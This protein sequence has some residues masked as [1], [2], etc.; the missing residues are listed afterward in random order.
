VEEDGRPAYAAW[1]TFMA[2]GTEAELGRRGV[3]IIAMTKDGRSV[4][5]YLLRYPKEGEAGERGARL[6]G[7]PPRW[8]EGHEPRD[9]AEAGA[10]RAIDRMRRMLARIEDLETALD[11]PLAVWPRLDEAWRRAENAEEPRLA[12]IVRQARPRAMPLRLRLVEQRLRRVLR[13]ERALRPI[14]RVEEMDRA[15]MIWL[16]RQPG[17]SLV[18][19]AGTDQRVMA[20]VRRESFDTLENRVVHAYARLAE[21]TARGW[22]RAHPKARLSERYRRVEAFRRICRRTATDLSGMGVGIADA[23][24]TPNYVLSQDPDYRATF[25]AWRRLLKDERETDDLWGWHAQ[26]WIDFCSL[27][28]VLCLMRLRDAELVAQSPIIWFG[29]PD[30]GRWFRQANPLAVVWLRAAGL[31]VEVQSRPESVAAEQFHAGAPLWL[32]IGW[33]SG[34]QPDRVAI[35]PLHG[36]AP[37]DLAAAARD[38]AEH[39]DTIGR[40]LPGAKPISAGL[41]LAQSFEGARSEAAERGGARVSALSLGAEGPELAEG[42]WLLESWIAGL[43]ADASP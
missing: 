30:R 21:R 34:G 37:P 20:I 17:A 29:A 24:A 25:E 40:Q 19:R 11:D 12:D 33:T 6:A 9:A 16:S 1:D 43:G 14:D 5:R 10:A 8:R 42:M 38:A 41:I 39:L 15:G 23:G 4:G 22:M 31:V 7:F 3:R 28:V 13:R 36:F 27:A 26:S 2:E 35:W 18:E 32:R